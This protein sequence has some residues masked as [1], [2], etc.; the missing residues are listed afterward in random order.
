M[1]RYAEFVPWWVTTRIYRE[2][3]IVYVEQSFR[4]GALF[5]YHFSSR[6]VLEWPTSVHITSSD[7]LFHYLDVHWHVKPL[8]VGGSV[9]TL[10]MDFR[11][12]SDMLQKLFDTLF[13]QETWQLL[14]V[15]ET[16]AHQLYG[17]PFR[18]Y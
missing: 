14:K 13:P 18:G 16:R 1:E 10:S 9:I 12:R 5:Q 15:F 7:R 2:D 17:D 4:L 6:A 8:D 11:L 3:N